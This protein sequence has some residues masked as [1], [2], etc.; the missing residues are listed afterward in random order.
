M[1]ELGIDHTYLISDVKGVVIVYIDEDTMKELNEVQQHIFEEFIKLCTKLDVK[2]YIVHGTLL[3]ALRYKGFFPMDD[4]IDVA[5]PR[6]DYDKLIREGQKHLPSNLFIQSIETDVEY[7]LTFAKIRDKNTAFIQPVLDNCNV[8]KGIYID[9]FPIDV[10]PDTKKKV[11]KKYILHKLYG[12]RVGTVLNIPTTSLKHRVFQTISKLLMPSWRKTAIKYANIYIAKEPT[13]KVILY[14]GKPTEQGIPAKWFDEAIDMKF[15]GMT[16]KA[17]K[18]YDA[19]LKRIY[20]DYMN[21]SPAA[22]Y[23]NEKGEVEISARYIDFGGGYSIGNKTT[24]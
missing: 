23:M 19:Y 15:N 6:E 11:A 14:G 13:A 16:V 8:N 17:P 24:F 4:D 18:M 5:M 9:V 7:P 21:Y 22:K 1:N 10:Y 2:Y 3:G 20:G 12:L